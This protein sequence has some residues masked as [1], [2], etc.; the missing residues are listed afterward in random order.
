MQN[1]MQRLCIAYRASKNITAG[2]SKLGV[3]LRILGVALKVGEKAASHL[4]LTPLHA[5]GNIQNQA[6]GAIDFLDLDLV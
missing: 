4:I 3:E 2:S 1:L 5:P 6:E